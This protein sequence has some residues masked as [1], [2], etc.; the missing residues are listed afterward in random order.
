MMSNE[1]SFLILKKKKFFFFGHIRRNCKMHA[2][3]IFA[4]EKHPE[5]KYNVW[6]INTLKRITG[7]V[8]VGR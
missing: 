7:K 1:I 8:A 3:L 2:K 4:I 5:Y 6:I